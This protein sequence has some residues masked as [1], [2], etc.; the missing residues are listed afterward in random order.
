M[1]AAKINLGKNPRILVA[2]TDR[3]GDVVLSLPVFASLKNAY[4]GATICAFAREYT[5]ELL[6]NRDDVD[7]IIVFNSPDSHVPWSALRGLV[8]EI[9]ARRFDVAIILYLNFSVAL[10]LTL[11]GIP[12]RIG[13]AT[14]AAQ[15]LLTDR[16]KQNR[17][18][19]TRHE[20]DHNL[21]LLKPLSVAPL[22]KAEIKVQDIYG[23]VF[24][25]TEGRPLIGVHP[26]HGGSSR[27]WP[28]DNYAKLITELSSSG[29]DVAVTGAPDERELAERIIEKSGVS[30]QAYL[31]NGG[32]SKLASVLAE[33]DGFVGPSTGPLHIASA[34][35]VRVVGVYCP[36]FVCL[37][38]RWGPIGPGGMAIT[39]DVEPCDKCVDEK[40]VHFDCMET[41]SVE[42]VKE[43][44][45]GMVLKPLV[46]R[47]L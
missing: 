5:R 47:N 8:S 24:K 17:S 28:E 12:R 41:I 42:K 14:K 43:A 10:C 25:K 35:G 19:G 45:L 30:V 27:N 31:E 1:T 15:F 21:D 9:K 37:P 4:P 16:I 20:A 6:E 18:K 13:P 29:C 38:E 39:P 22:R 32:L 34:V 23:T 44:V 2:R 33:L 40:C 36:I 26:G 46:T 11:A 7:E 3:I